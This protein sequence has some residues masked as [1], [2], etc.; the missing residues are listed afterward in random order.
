ML[1]SCTQDEQSPRLRLKLTTFDE[2]ALEE[3][4]LDELEG[5]ELGRSRRR[6][7]AKGSFLAKVLSSVS[8]YGGRIESLSEEKGRQGGTEGSH[9]RWLGR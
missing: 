1:A 9:D 3:G 5:M 6:Q 2:E 8:G 4:E 7:T